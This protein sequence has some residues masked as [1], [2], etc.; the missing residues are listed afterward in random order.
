M[1]KVDYDW[2][3]KQF[4]RAKVRKI[5]G[6]S[7]IELLK[8]WETLDFPSEELEHAA[9][10]TF[11]ALAKGHSLVQ[12][13]PERWLPAQAGFMLQVGDTVRV[14]SDAF[15]GEAGRVH[16]GRI[17]RVVAKRSGDIIVKHIDGI[18][19]SRDDA[20]YPAASLEKKV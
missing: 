14:R 20:R 5:T 16:N 11:A 7:A 19:P 8:V 13:G 12:D 9:I 1:P 18:E 3:K 4:A 2:V 15:S 10:D 6:N 17:G